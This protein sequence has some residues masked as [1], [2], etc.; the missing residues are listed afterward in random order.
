ML[1][2]RTILIL[3]IVFFSASSCFATLLTGLVTDDKGE[4]IPFVNVFI[5][6]TTRGT[7]TNKD[8]FYQLDL[9][10]GSYEISYK[11]MGYKVHTEQVTMAD[12]KLT[13]NVKLVD[14]TVTLNDVNITANGEDPAYRVIRNAIKK[15]KYYLEQVDQ[16]SCDV[17]IKGL[18]RITRHPKKKMGMEIDP[19]GEIDTTTGIIYLSESVSKFNFKQAHNIKEE[20]ISSKVSGDNKAFSYNRASDMLFN[21]YENLLEVEG[22]SE[23]G[24]VSPISNNALFFYK[25]KLIRSEEHTSELQSH[26]F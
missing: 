21:F 8:G 23:R 19:E 7:T 14:E 15:R 2:Q 18:Q 4:G 1:F 3:G 16:Y 6:N 13:V 11:M 20:M 25:Y 17:Y 12:Q 5:K 9:Q 10:P 26:S 22:L 24:F